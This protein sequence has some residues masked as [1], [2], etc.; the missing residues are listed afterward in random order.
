[1]AGR[2]Y[3]GPNTPGGGGLRIMK[4]PAHDPKTTPRTDYN[5]F[6]FDSESGDL[7][8]AW[9]VDSSAQTAVSDLGFVPL[10]TSSVMYESGW[11]ELQGWIVGTLG[12]GAGAWGKTPS[13]GFVTRFNQ[14]A[15]PPP[16]Y[17]EE[18]R[19]LALVGAFPT[20]LA[21]KHILWQLPATD[22]A[23]PFAASTGKI[24][25]FYKSG[26]QLRMPRAGKS[27]SSSTL[28][29]FI[30][31]ENLR[32]AKIIKAGRITLSG[33]GPVD[34]TLPGPKSP[35]IFVGGQFSEPGQPVTFPY[36]NLGIG[37]TSASRRVQWQILG[38][39]ATLR[40][41][42]KGGNT[43]DVS[44]YVVAEDNSSPTSGSASW[45]RS[46][47]D[48][49]GESYV[50]IRR[51]G[52]AEPPNFADILV[53]SRWQ[54]M[55]LV[56]NGFVPKAAFADIGGGGRQVSVSI[57]TLGYKP[58]V[59]QAW[60]FSYISPNLN[61]WGYDRWREGCVAFL[62]HPE[63]AGATGDTAFITV[64]DGSVTFTS[65]GPNPNTVGFEDFPSVRYF[66][67]YGPFQSE[68]SAYSEW[69]QFIGVR[70]YVFAI[71]QG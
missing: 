1:M 46:G 3:I 43:V 31:H 35:N 39:G 50:Q 67:I 71:P 53:D 30:L 18:V 15:Y 61:G 58:L 28:T 12:F 19:S 25:R 57:P 41:R 60:W 17:V 69:N 29:D 13:V 4:N 14:A 70:Y 54:C 27:A 55:P 59:L 21:T 56:A 68:D 34:I 33:G 64:A 44:Y 23:V 32:P 16:E 20:P 49:D 66:K 7:A 37:G 36:S 9:G 26:S 63:F 51:P 47:V 11:W 8:Y 42:E 22:A 62:N 24:P 10:I 40:L 5:K 45:M 2:I 38:G 6:A 65:Y 52:C 48:G